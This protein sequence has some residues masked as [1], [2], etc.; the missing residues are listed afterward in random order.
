MG[1]DSTSSS[2]PAPACGA[3]C[4]VGCGSGSGSGVEGA[5]SSGGVEGF[6]AG[7]GVPL[8]GGGVEGFS[9]E[10]G[11]PLVGGGGAFS[12][13][14]F[15]TWTGGGTA[16]CSWNAGGVTGGVGVPRTGSATLPLA[17]PLGVFL[18]FAGPCWAAREGCSFAQASFAARR[19]AERHKTSATSRARDL[20]LCRG[21]R[22]A[23]FRCGCPRVKSLRTLPLVAR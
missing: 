22:M 14:G 7:G 11:V 20:R 6:S 2:P 23:V 17:L 15:W 1:P 4:G 21:A 3:G 13:G 10:G 16:G 5:R 8:V 9:A 12:T 18:P 19:K